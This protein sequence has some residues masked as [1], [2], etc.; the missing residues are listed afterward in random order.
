MAVITA[1]Q[2]TELEKSTIK[3]ITRRLIPFLILLYMINFLDRTNVGFAAKGMEADLG[4][5][6]AA[7]GAGAGI[8]FLAYF[9]CEVPS[10]VALHKFGARVWISRIMVT[11]GIIATAMAFIQSTEHFF[12]LRVL[13]GAAEAGFYPGIIFFLSLWYPAR[14]R[15]RVMAWFYLGIPMASVLGAPL[16]TALISWGEKIGFDGWRMMYFV[17]GFPAIILGV[18]T[19]FYLTDR[20]EKA[21]WLSTEQRQWLVNDLALEET[22]KD[23]E[24][25]ATSSHWAQIKAVLKNKFVWA[26]ALIYFGITSGS[27]AMNFF[28]PSVLQSFQESMGLGKDIMTIGWLTAIPYAV[29][30]VAMT[31]WARRSDRHNERRYHAG[32][33]A[34]VAAVAITAALLINSPVAIILGFVALASGVYSA[35][36]VFWSVPSQ[37][38][39]GVGAATG[40]GLINSVGNL[41]GFTGPMIIGAIKESTGS[42]TP[43]FLVIA[44]IVFTAGVSFIVL[45][46]KKR[47]VTIDVPV[48]A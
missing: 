17:E 31:I 22:V 11:W 36:N 8:F 38:L 24:V 41:S 32:G 13:L 7:Y 40:L 42:Y 45:M 18:V 16:S 4:I 33:A 26:L 28:L 48:N 20:P 44:A 35:V 3:K 5:S 27:N 25:T 37:L 19:F 34:I 23:L 10:N 1:T 21:K 9:L 39:T 2:A 12:I 29:A 30:A 6:A 14:Y 15:A 46:R 47:L 43:A